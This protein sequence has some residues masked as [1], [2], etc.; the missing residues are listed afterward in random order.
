[1]AWEAGT[2]N[3]SRAKMK[4]ARWATPTVKSVEATLRLVYLTIL[5]SII[6]FETRGSFCKKYYLVVIEAFHLIIILLLYV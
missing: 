6:F 5:Y 3:S 1:M 4:K 2:K